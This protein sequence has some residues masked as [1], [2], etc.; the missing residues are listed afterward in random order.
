MPL[1]ILAA[2]GLTFACG[3]G[4]GYV[5]GRETGGKL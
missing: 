3:V 2:F 5:L 1:M 4:W